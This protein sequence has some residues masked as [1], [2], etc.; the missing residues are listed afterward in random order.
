MLVLSLLTTFLFTSCTKEEPKKTFTKTELLC[1]APW[2]Y[3]SITI[4]P[5]LDIGGSGTIITDWFA[6]MASCNKDDLHL[7]YANNKGIIDE[8]PTKCFE[9]LPQSVGFDWLFNVD[10]T[11]IIIDA[12]R[13]EV[14]VELNEST[15]VIERLMKG[16]DLGANPS[17]N[18]KF[19]TTLV[20]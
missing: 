9:S 2:K 17:V 15:L 16:E 14:I 7:F 6:Q 11:K 18:Y 8:G 12:V 4:E 13:E 1:S 20:H 3:K 19:I 10:E 5:G